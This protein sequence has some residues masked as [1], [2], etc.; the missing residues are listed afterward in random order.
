MKPTID[1]SSSRRRTNASNTS[2]PQKIAEFL[3]DEN[4]FVRRI[5]LANS[6]AP[7]DV[8]DLLIR[9]GASVDLRGK[10]EIDP[11]VSQK[12]L[13]LVAALGPFG[14][15]LVAG[16][17]NAQERI[18]EDI[19]AQ[20]PD[21]I[22]VAVLKH[23]NCPA[24]LLEAA[25]VSMCSEQ[26]RLAAIHPRAP[27]GLI[28]ELRSA[29]A[30]GQLETIVGSKEHLADEVIEQLFALGGWGRVIAA[31]QPNC[32]HTL[33]TAIA[34]DKD[35]R[36]R[37]AVVEN[38]NTPADALGHLMSIDDD[39]VRL[40]LI[41]HPN[42][43]QGLLVEAAS[44]PHVEVRIAVARNERTPT[45]AL[46]ILA[47]DGAHQVREII[48]Q[49]PHLPFETIE[50]FRRL[51]SAKDLLNFIEPD[52]ALSSDEIARLTELGTWTRRLAARH[53]NTDG[54]TLISLACDTDPVAREWSALHPNMPSEFLDLLERAGA[55]RDLMGKTPPDPTLGESVLDEL[56]AHGAWAKRI[57]AEH[58]NTPP[59]LLAEFAESED[60]AIRASVASHSQTPTSALVELARDQV[61]QVRFSVAGHS[62]ID[63]VAAKILATDTIAG[64]RNRL[65]QNPNV[66]DAILEQLENDLNLDIAAAAKARRKSR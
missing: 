31:A 15:E 32:P 8:V 61:P 44:H 43:P 41:Y 22:K 59:K 30:D 33:L 63:F 27:A 66:S 51:G 11:T 34:Q 64:I 37:L 16:H 7:A 18:L 24:N 20:E 3:C 21:S 38:P 29:G 60:A 40:R 17:P 55:S 26:R 35:W 49:H 9:V 12:E 56:I 19:V 42:A 48:A 10:G 6:F 1:I 28:A 13:E 39:N 52:A 25:C 36:V 58:P 54:D 57:V 5:A 45:R 50:Q 4:Y 47:A 62:A 65:I 23:A 46:R 14:R 53:P 2:D